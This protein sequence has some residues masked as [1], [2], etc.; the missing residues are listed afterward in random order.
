[1]KKRIF[2]ML[3]MGAMV[4]A[5]VSMFTSCKDYDDDINKLQTQID[6]ITAQNL[7]SQL[8]TLQ[9]SLQKAQSD[10]TAAESKAKEALAA[11]EAAAAAANAEGGAA[12]AAA[13]AQTTAD[14]AKAAAEAAEAAAAAAAKQETVDAL[15][16]AIKDIKAILDGK[17]STADYEKDQEAVKKAIEDAIKGVEAKIAAINEGLVTLDDVKKLLADEGIATNA[18]VQNLSN[19]IDA[20]NAFKAKMEGMSPVVDEAWKK[21]VDEA[22]ASL[23]KISGDITAAAKAAS[24]AQTAATANAVDIATLK[25]QMQDAETAIQAL[26][27]LDVANQMANIGNSIDLLTVLVNKMLTSVTLIPQRYINGIEA[28]TFTSVRYIPQ[29]FNPAVAIPLAYRNDTDGKGLWLWNEGGS[30][31]T[32][33]G[34]DTDGVWWGTTPY[35]TNDFTDHELVAVTGARPVTIDNGET[36]AE[37]RLSP[38]TVAVEDIDVDNIAIFGTVAQSETRAANLTKN[39]PVS[40]SFATLGANGNLTVKL[41][42]TVTTSLAYGGSVY[43]GDGTAA[44]SQLGTVN[45]NI[46]SLMVPRKANAEKGIDYAE[47]Y[48]EYSLLD[49]EV[50][51]PRIAALNYGVFN[52]VIWNVAH[53]PSRPMQYHFVDSTLI[54][55]SQVDQYMYVKE[56]IQY[57]QPYD[58]KQLVTGC[59]DNI[60]GGHS[61]ITKDELAKYGI[62]FR[63]AIPKAQYGSAGNI[64]FN[65]TNQQVF[66]VLSEN[67]PH[68]IIQAKLP[69]DQAASTNRALIGK[70]PIVRV[71]LVD[72]VRNNLIDQAYFKVK[73]VDKTPKKD[74]VPVEISAEGDLSC[75][76]NQMRIKWQEFIEQVYAKVS[77][78][79]GQGLSWNEFRAVYPQADVMRDNTKFND[80][81]TNIWH[82]AING[83]T[84]QVTIWWLSGADPSTQADANEM[85]WTLGEDDIK[86]ILPARKKTFTTKVIFVSN[87]PTDYGNIELTLKYT[88]KIPDIPELSYYQNYWY[89]EYNSHYVLP[90]QYNTKAYYDQLIGATANNFQYNAGNIRPANRYTDEQGNFPGAYCVYNNNL[91]NAFTFNQEQFLADGVTPNRYYNTPIPTLAYQCA[92][93]DYQFRKSQS[94]SGVPNVAPE[95]VVEY[96]GK[97]EPLLPTLSGTAYAKGAD[98]TPGFYVLGTQ[99]QPTNATVNAKGSRYAAYNLMTQIKTGG[100]KNDAIWMNWYNDDKPNTGAEPGTLAS[101]DGSWNWNVTD[102]GSRPYLFADHFNAHNQVLINEI[103]S[104][105][106]GNAP[107]FTNKNKVKMGMFIRWNKYNAELVKSYNICLVAPLDI[108]ANLNGYFEEGIISGSFVNCAGA[109]TMVDFR[110][111]EVAAN[112]ATAAEIAAAEA[113]KRGSSEFIQYRDR[114]Y[115]YYEC[116]EPVFDLTKIKYGMKYE[117]GNVVVDNTVTIKNVE[118]KNKGL[119]SAEIEQYTNGNVVLSIEQFNPAGV[120]DTQ[121]L[122]FKNNGGSNVEAEVNVFIP[123]TMNYGFGS[124]TKYVQLKLYPR[125]GVP[126]A[127]RR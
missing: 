16:D 65:F 7:Q 11:A 15:E 83:G 37:Y 55:N 115:N 23:T 56:E 36:T 93:W 62:A 88:V 68:N 126:A 59:Y 125:G 81:G 19:Q 108:N 12:D 122:R 21:K 42:K 28:I 100:T 25:D 4:I 109:F 95:Y 45:A 121:W 38:N 41:R 99:Y 31:I 94:V 53:D 1:M 117:N 27:G 9:S 48:S 60:A 120:A 18:V 30:G 46:V 104:N 96:P 44:Q 40:A 3:L 77:G 76:G 58:L 50:I 43:D 119:T 35:Y 17:V 32:A 78:S 74:V 24:A 39:S 66:A 112:P 124:V 75:A 105:G 114:L 51:L 91:F 63:F 8:T 67:N 102:G 61:E 123:A 69:S 71:M 79:Y 14:A 10:A 49:E 73:F 34:A 33:N 118:R 47:I 80:A 22:I 57:D 70:E 84:G 106:V 2:G 110:G 85:Y 64:N 97:E 72:T 82:G 113:A 127:R 103:E 86:Q 20:L 101:V 111:Y 54:Y 98:N 92:D 5:S 13:A 107:T 90:V 52:G 116:Q 29:V 6:A 89:D 26:N 87:R